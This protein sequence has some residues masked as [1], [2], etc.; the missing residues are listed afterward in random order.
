MKNGA[1]V[2]I[3]ITLKPL[4]LHYLQEGK[5]KRQLNQNFGIVCHTEICLTVSRL[6]A[7]LSNM[8]AKFRGHSLKN[9]A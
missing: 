9:E 4:F 1:K 8:I 5:Y 6:A 3:D 7:K 2:L